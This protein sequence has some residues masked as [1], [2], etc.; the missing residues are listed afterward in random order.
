[1]VVGYCRDMGRG[2]RQYARREISL[3]DTVRAPKVVP[4]WNFGP[5]LLS[6]AEQVDAAL[7]A[8]LCRFRTH[9]AIGLP[10][11]AAIGKAAREIG[12]APA[13]RGQ[14]GQSLFD[15]LD[16][17]AAESFDGIDGAS[18]L[19][20]AEFLELVTSLLDEQNEAVT[21]CDQCQQPCSADL[22][23][24]LPG[25]QQDFVV[26]DECCWDERLRQ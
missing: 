11:H 15:L 22:A 26:G 12:L 1:M 14:L 13:Q 23:H 20:P 10:F 21:T 25:D 18:D 17:A 24:Y 6:S 9:A 16:E 5:K 8:A 19:E 4:T 3:S 7:V 2:K